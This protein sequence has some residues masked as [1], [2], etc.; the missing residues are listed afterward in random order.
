MIE[1]HTGAQGARDKRCSGA[2]LQNQM[3]ADRRRYVNHWIPDTK[4]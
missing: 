2:H 4:L 3:N 1:E